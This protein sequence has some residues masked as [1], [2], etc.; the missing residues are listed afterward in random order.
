MDRGLTEQPATMAL[1]RHV[2]SADLDTVDAR[3]PVML[4]QP[5]REHREVGID[6]RTDGQ[7]LRNQLTQ[8]GPWLSGHSL[9][10]KK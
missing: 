10:K 8:K 7:I 6:E 1:L 9:V 4:R 3:D 5:L 2:H